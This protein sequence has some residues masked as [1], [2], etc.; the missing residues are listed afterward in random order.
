MDTILKGI[1]LIFAGIGNL[2]F[3]IAI[4]VLL[5]GS[6]ACFFIYMKITDKEKLGLPSTRARIGNLYADFETVN[7]MYE[8]QSVEYYSFVFYLRRGIFVL[9]TFGLFNYPG[10]QI[11]AFLQLNIF[12]IIYVGHVTFY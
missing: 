8:P 2:S 1:V 5:Y 3:A 11:Q 4:F 7:L 12:Y 10:I 9:I 6:Y